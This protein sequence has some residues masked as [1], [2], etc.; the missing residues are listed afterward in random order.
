MALY[1]D[2]PAGRVMSVDALRGFDMFWIIGGSGILSGL[3]AMTGNPFAGAVARQLQHPKFLGFTALD[4]VFPLFL[5]VMGVSLAF[6][7]AGRVRRGDSRRNIMIH[8]ARRA[9]ILYFLGMVM[10]AGRI[11][12]LG[13]LRYTGVL[14]RIAACY[15]CAALIS[16]HTRVK[17]K[18]L[19]TAG[20]TVGY[21]LAMI[22]IPV[23]GHGAGVL[24]PEGNLA[25]YVDRLLLPGVL[26]QGVYDNEGILTTLPAVA[27]TLLG[28]L[29]GLWLRSGAS[30]R[31]KASGLAVGGATALA[32]GLVWGMV[33]PINKLMWTSSFVF[34]TGGIGALFLSLFY[35]LIDVR[36]YRSWAFPFVVI[37]MN[38]LAIYFIQGVFD[39]GRIVHVFTHEF[40]D[41]LGSYRPL[42]RS[43]SILMVKWMFLY[44]LFRRRL[45][46]K[47]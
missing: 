12:A 23:P 21:W 43:V 18:I 7:L 27:T 46:L 3:C 13:G 36:G 10:E 37:G 15:F 28:V 30:P 32:L 16:V 31:R 44:V 4:M 41:G 40:I 33:F 5:F 11:D 9:V 8:V 6:S 1:E 19:W 47:L 29:S 17:G 14:H 26:Y 24:T 42:F 35:W 38:A 2:L 39:F 34:V 25:G 45:F 22:F 20:I